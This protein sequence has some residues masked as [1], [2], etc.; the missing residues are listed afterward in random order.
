[1]AFPMLVPS[2]SFHDI[3]H[4]Y[5]SVSH[6]C[7]LNHVHFVTSNKYNWYNENSNC[8]FWSRVINIELE[9][10]LIDSFGD[11][12]LLEPATVL[13]IQITVRVIEKWNSNKEPARL[14]RI[15]YP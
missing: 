12:Q 3:T 14:M 4:E 15:G 2:T 10:T 5:K 7:L 1:M 13:D 11:I 8:Y 6:T 9:E